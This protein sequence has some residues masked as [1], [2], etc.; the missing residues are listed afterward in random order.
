MVNNDTHECMEK[1]AFNKNCLG[2]YQLNQDDYRCYLLSRLGSY[3][4]RTNDTSISYIKTQHQ[5]YSKD[6]NSISFIVLETSPI[7][8]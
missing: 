8:Y 4:I 1:C 6:N 2:V 3:P 5:R 7:T